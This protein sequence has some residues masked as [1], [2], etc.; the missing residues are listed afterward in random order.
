[1]KCRMVRCHQFLA[2]GPFLNTWS[3]PLT[4]WSNNVSYADAD[5][6]ADADAGDGMVSSPGATFQDAKSRLALGDTSP[7]SHG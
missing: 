6:D 4:Q 2:N 7:L 1:M 3:R 5:A